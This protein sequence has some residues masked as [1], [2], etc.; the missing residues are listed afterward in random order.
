MAPQGTR[1]RDRHFQADVKF[2]NLQVFCDVHTRTA[3]AILPQAA[4]EED[5]HFL[6]EDQVAAALN[7]KKT[8]SC[9]PTHPQDH[10]TQLRP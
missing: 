2:R 5:L 3:L 9:H 6:F 4:E 10:N 1:D 8:L 7:H